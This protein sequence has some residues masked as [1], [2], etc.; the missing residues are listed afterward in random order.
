MFDTFTFT[1][2]IM[3][4]LMDIWPWSTLKYT[5]MYVIE[6]ILSRV[7]LIYWYTDILINGLSPDDKLTS[8]FQISIFDYNY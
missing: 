7:G 5:D 6:S 2:F 1:F 8:D 4:I 3:S